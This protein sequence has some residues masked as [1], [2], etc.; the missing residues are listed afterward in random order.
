MAGSGQWVGLELG[1]RQ[2]W[3]SVRAMAWVRVRTKAMVG[4]EQWVGLE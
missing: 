3:V 2:C 1:P 4:P